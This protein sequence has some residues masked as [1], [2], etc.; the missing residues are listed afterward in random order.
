MKQPKDD[1]R[2][3]V[4]SK[5]ITTGQH[6]IPAYIIKKWKQNVIITENCPFNIK[7]RKKFKK[8]KKERLPQSERS[9]CLCVYHRWSQSFE[10]NANKFVEQPFFKLI[11]ELEKDERDI[12]KFDFIKDKDKALTIIDYYLLIKR[13]MYFKLNNSN[14]VF[15]NFVGVK[16]GNYTKEEQET[17]ERKHVSYYFNN[18]M[19]GME[20]ISY[21]MDTQFNRHCSENDVR[22]LNE[23]QNWFYIR[24]HD[25][26]SR[27][28]LPDNWNNWQII[29]V[30]PYSIFISQAFINYLYGFTD[31]LQFLD[32]KNPPIPIRKIVKLS[33][34]INNLALSVYD[35]WIIF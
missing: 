19:I 10:V 9:E 23:H 30:S 16:S 32:I 2:P 7:F 14:E 20:W 28:V 26:T 6:I 13:R 24:I 4:L 34:I 11:D 18:Q 8:G 25:K 3:P 5:N 21:L 33:S 1:D 29:S 31:Y 17:L 22:T 15:K 35:K 27:F 12:I